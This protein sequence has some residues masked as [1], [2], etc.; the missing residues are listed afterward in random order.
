M[1]VSQTGV[2]YYES[3]EIFGN[4]SGAQTRPASQ[5]T[6]INHV[7]GVLYEFAST[8]AELGTRR[9]YQISRKT[10]NILPPFEIPPS[11]EVKKGQTLPF[12]I[13]FGPNSDR[14]HKDPTSLASWD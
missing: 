10:R 4:L 1:G 6:H 3:C 9:C 12:G 8:S 11:S 7:R 5:Q 13:D 2:R 14:C